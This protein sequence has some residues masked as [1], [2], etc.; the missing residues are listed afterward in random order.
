[1]GPHRASTSPPSGAKSDWHT[2]VAD[3]EQV[4][5]QE[6]VLSAQGHLPAEGDRLPA[7]LTDGQGRRARIRAAAAEVTKIVEQQAQA[8]QARD[9]AARQRRERAEDTSSAPSLSSLLCKAVGFGHRW[10][11]IRSG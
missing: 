5:A 3:A 8:D 10:G 1:V 6:D 9:A 7:T 2:Q 4:D 11:L